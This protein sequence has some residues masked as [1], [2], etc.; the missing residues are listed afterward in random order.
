MNTPPGYPPLAVAYRVIA[1]RWRLGWELYISD[2]EHGEI[3]VTNTDGTCTDES[4]SGCADA[5]YM[6]R[7]YL[8]TVHDL[9]DDE[10]AALNITIVAE[11]G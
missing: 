10:K 6:V 7:D 5:D 8:A 2:A 11:D 3:G 4:H 1:K 9:T